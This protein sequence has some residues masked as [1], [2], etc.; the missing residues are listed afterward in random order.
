MKYTNLSSRAIIGRFYE[1]LA[2]APKSQLLADIAGAPFPSD[3]ASEEYAW[4]GMAPTMREWISGRHA[5]SFRQSD[6][7]IK[8]KK[9]EATLRIE[10]DD[11]RRDK[12]GQIMVRVDELAGRAADSH[13]LSLIMALILAGESGLCYDSLYFFDTTH[14]EGDSGSQSNLITIDISALSTSVHSDGTVGKYNPSAGEMSLCI[15]RAVQTI[16]GFKDDQGEPFNE[17]ATQFKVV[18]GTNLLEPITAALNNQFISSGEQNT[19]VNNGR[20]KVSADFSARLTTLTD[21]FD[22]YRTDG[23]VKPFIMQ[24]E[25]PLET[26]M[27]AENSEYE[28]DQDAWEFGVNASRNVGYGLWQHACRIIM[29]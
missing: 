9:F 27:K 25:V 18:A 22:V 1:T 4:L 17:T 23:R 10:K 15:Q 20:Y 11:I 7:T 19:L 8:N 28:F 13:W 3:Q 21:R 2:L 6:Y 16:M 14:S 12:T 5:K 24:E 29:T 26:K